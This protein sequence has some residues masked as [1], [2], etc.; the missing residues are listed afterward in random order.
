MTKRTKKIENKMDKF[1]NQPSNSPREKIERWANNWEKAY[2][3]YSFFLPTGI[4]II[5]AVSPT[6]LPNLTWWI[7]YPACIILGALFFFLYYKRRLYN[8]IKSNIIEKDIESNFEA[9]D[10]NLLVDKYTSVFNSVANGINDG[11]PRTQLYG[12]IAEKMLEVIE[13]RFTDKLQFGLCI[14]RRCNDEAKLIWHTEIEN[15][16]LKSLITYQEEVINRTDQKKY[17]YGEFLFSG[18]DDAVLLDAAG[19]KA[20]LKQMDKE[21]MNHIKS[22]LGRTRVASICSNNIGYY[23][24]IILYDAKANK[25]SEQFAKDIRCD[26]IDPMLD[27]C[28]IIDSHYGGGLDG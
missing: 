3:G 21:R 14:F 10:I 24:E 19:V 20:S 26:L 8:D 5:A 4:T 17:Y 22:Y 9:R 7:F 13:T 27:I 16:K 12:I 11:L 2:T 6:F 1:I 18:I 15:R 23:V 25:I 28:R